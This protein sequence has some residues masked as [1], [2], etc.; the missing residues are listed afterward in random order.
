MNTTVPS[1]ASH[2][3]TNYWGNVP[4][5]TVV[6]PPGVHTVYDPKTGRTT[7][8]IYHHPHLVDNAPPITV[9]SA[10]SPSY[11]P[12]VPPIQAE[13]IWLEPS[14]VEDKAELCWYKISKNLKHRFPSKTYANADELHDAIQA[15]QRERVSQLVDLVI[16]CAFTEMEQRATETLKFG[17]HFENE[18]LIESLL[19]EELLGERALKPGTKKELKVTLLEM[20]FSTATF[21]A[22]I[23]SNTT[24]TYYFRSSKLWE[25]SKAA[26][27]EALSEASKAADAEA[28]SEASKSA[29]ACAVTFPQS[30]DAV[31]HR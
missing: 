16:K 18:T 12:P 22:K 6:T 20:T 19:L 23:V 31:Q 24:H 21:E 5:N 1:T 14:R 27:V 15:N 30:A 2:I 26:D 8:Y 3:Y 9:A 11:V 29:S 25:P 13:P 28:L 10:P 17:I 4:S 7:Q